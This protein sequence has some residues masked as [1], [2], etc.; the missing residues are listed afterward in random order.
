MPVTSIPAQ[1]A[2]ALFLLPL[3]VWGT[4][5]VVAQVRRTDQI[6][7]TQALLIAVSPVNEQVVWVGGAS[8]T[9]LRTVDGGATWQ[10][11][12]VPG[13]DKLQFRD[14]HG[15]DA[16]IAFLLSIG[17]GA[18]SR[19]YK[20]TDAGRTWALQFTNA[21]PKGFYDCFDFWD[22]GRGIVIGDAIEGRIAML[23]TGDG[24]AT[25]VPVPADRLPPARAGEGSFAASGTC[26][27]TRPGGHAWIVMSNPEQGRVLHTEDFGR[28]WSF[29]ALPVTTRAGIGPQSVSFRDDRHGVVLG[30]GDSA[31]L[32]DTLTATTGDG[33]KTWIT[34]AR[35][36]LAKGIWGGQ[37]I[38][39]ARP[40]T[41]IAVGPSGAVYSRDEGASWTAIDS[42][43]YWSV[44]FA[45]PR[46]G[47]AVG[48]G[49]RITKLAG[50]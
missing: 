50:F 28:S 8:G 9:W 6:S 4:R 36:P 27:V 35:P 7:G 12:V 1:L 42:D 22:A 24:G 31:T 26:L 19:I 39:G 48:V 20:T 17:E 25:W 34:R 49:G 15:V 14:V 11:G 32:S 3:V 38:P 45:S 18:Q 46:A 43:N 37:Y 30:G 5:P 2:A 40:G 47:W 33:G 23:T 41:V 13:G 21:D 16:E 29:A 44:G 10:G